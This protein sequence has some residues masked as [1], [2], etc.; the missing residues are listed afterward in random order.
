MRNVCMGMEWF[1]TMI[2]EC[3]VGSPVDVETLARP[4]PSRRGMGHA[5]TL[6]CSDRRVT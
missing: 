5:D 6:G 2:I 4:V 1:V 3:Y